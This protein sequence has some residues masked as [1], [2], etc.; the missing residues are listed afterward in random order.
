MISWLISIFYSPLSTSE[1][2]DIYSISK[3]LESPNAAVQNGG[4]QSDFRRSKLARRYFPSCWI[5]TLQWDPLAGSQELALA[6]S[7]HFPQEKDVES[8]M[9]AAVKSFLRARRKGTC[10]MGH[11]PLI[12][13]NYQVYLD[14]K[15]SA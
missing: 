6:L 1:P 3:L 10:A 9:G 4:Y 5:I 12:T 7:Y 15:V 11:F 14:N 2:S 13:F 8:K